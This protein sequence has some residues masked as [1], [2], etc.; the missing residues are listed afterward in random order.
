MKEGETVKSMPR[1][2][3]SLI[4]S[5]A[6]IVLAACGGSGTGARTFSGGTAPVSTNMQIRMGD[7]P[8]DSIVSFE[9]TVNSIALAPQGGGAPVTVL[10][11]PT[12]IELAHM[13]G[14]VE[15]LALVS[16]PA[17]T[18][19]SA[20]LIVT[21]PEV[22]IIDPNTHQPTQISVN[23][24][25][26]TIVVNFN[27]AV[28]V[29]SGQQVV[30]FD[31]NLASSVSIS[32]NV[33]TITPVFNVSVMTVTAGVEDD[34]AGEIEDLTGNVTSVGASSFTVS[35]QQ[36]AQSL[37]FQ[38]DSNTAFEGVI[39]LS[40]LT[41]GTLVEVE[42]RTQTDGSLLATKVS[43]EVEGAAKDAL[44]AEG[45]ITQV[46]GTPA[47]QFQMVVQE[48][49]STTGTAPSLGS[50]LTVQID[51]STKFVV[52]SDVV[53]LSNLPFTPAFTASTITLGQR[54]EAAATTPSTTSISASRVRL[55]TQAL[56]GTVSA[57]TVS[58]GQATFTLTV[59]SDSAFAL[60]TGK[61]TVSVVQQPGTQL[62]DIAGVNNGDA[63][64][65]RGLLFFDGSAFHMV[66]ARITAP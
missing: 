23:L 15:P 64:R 12:R 24:P 45:V 53:D 32:G 26:T 19:T 40:Q 5:L 34:E 39:G 52:P 60:L 51:G 27:P 58:S 59:A 65:V 14:T 10:S 30:S 48:V 4:V 61:T 46:T 1:I 56:T 54:V 20:T 31:L 9:I 42:G 8:A 33:A 18:Y 6:A 55:D 11:T 57:Y 63:V 50:T 47:T 66:A 3:P 43:A 25:Q 2:V 35:V 17:G 16:V 28:S 49:N 22:V 13:A 44:E 29:G 36:S 21:N 38:V 62:K 41:A 37:T 7:G